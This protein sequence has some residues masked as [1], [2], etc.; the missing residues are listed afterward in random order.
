MACYAPDAVQ[1][2][3]DELK[4]RDV[5]PPEDSFCVWCHHCAEREARKFILGA[6]KTTLRPM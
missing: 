3:I 5:Q 2:F 4:A 6:L 1:E